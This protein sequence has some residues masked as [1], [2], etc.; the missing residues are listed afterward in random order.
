MD[1]QKEALQRIISTL[2]NKNDEI[3]NFVDTLNHTLKGVQTQLSQCNNALENSEELLEFATRSLDIKEPEEFSKAARQIKDRV[4]MASAFR[5]SLK[6]K[7][8]DNMTHLMVDFSQERQM[9][10]TLKFLPVPKAPEIDI[11]DCLVADNSVTVAW[12][13]PEEDN[14][15]DHYIL[16]YRKT[17]FDGLPR[18]KDERCWEIIDN[19]KGLEYTLSGLKFDSK[20]MNFRVR[21]CNKAVAGEYSDPVTLETKAL[22][23]NLD[24][25]SSHL[26]LKVEDACVE[27][28]PTG[29]KGQDS[30]VKGKE[31]KGSVHVTSLKKHTRSGTPSP[32]RT[33]VGSRPPAVRGS[34]DR[35]TG[36]SYTVLG[37][38]AIESGQHYWE[39][40]A[41]KDCK[42]YSVGVAYKT[43]GK[44]DQL[45]KTNTS[46]CIHVNNWLQNTFAAKHNNK[47]KALDVTVPEK[48]GVFCDFDGGQLSFYDA[49]SK[50]L[51]YSF[52]TKFTQPVLPGFMVWCG[53]LALSTGM[54]V[55]SAVRT[56]QKSENGMTGSAS[57]LNNVTQKQV[58]LPIQ[59][60][61]NN[62]VTYETQPSE[63]HRLM[64][65]ISKNVILALFTLASSAFLLFQL[66]YYKH[67][68][69]AKN[70][71][72]LSKS[73][74]SRIGF[75]STQWRAVKKFI[76]LTSSQNVPVFLIDPLILELISKNFEQVK[77]TSS[78]SKCKFFC[79]Q[80][81]FTTFALQYHQWKN[82]EGWFPVAESMGFQCLK[83][84]N[85]DPRL[86]G[87]DSLSGT[88]IPLH[89]ICKWAT[90]AIHLVVFHGRSG[91]YLWHGHLRLKGHID[92]KFVPFRKLQF[93]RYP[94]A[95]DRP[96]LQQVTIDGLEVLIPKDPTHFLEEIP[97][98]RFI[99]CRYKEARTFFQQYLD[100]N[101][102]EAVTF[103]KSAK[104]LLQLAAKILNKLGVKFWLSSGTCLGWY[105]QCSII[106]YSKD[107]DLGVFIQD[108]K[109][110][111]ILAFQEAGLPLKHKFGKVED[112]LELSF[113]GKDGVKL[114]IFFFYEETDYMWNGG[115]Q[116]KTG[117]KFKYLFPKFTLCWT[118]FVDM[119][120][121]VPCETTEYIE[122][123][124][125][126]SWRIPIKTWD[127]KSSPPNVRPNGIWPISEWDEVIQ[128]Y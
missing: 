121:H 72:G 50:Q 59:K 32:K 97:H 83:T 43:L 1:A 90:H 108:Y 74:G 69:S 18:V 57:S 10:Q 54:Q 33:S 9:L 95:F 82:E 15:I 63:Y 80:R 41:Q 119:K 53:G 56:L 51:L 21:A 58:C 91:S 48:I 46:W 70:G 104:E 123:N 47:V 52:K 45:G 28:D 65:K 94:G 92:R 64:S 20:Y 71:A 96:E 36:E 40:K 87:I 73:K 16:E 99:E 89:C 113:Q 27:W 62:W 7:V 39:V 66:Y 68:L 98:S 125:G 115:T 124:Y 26:N 6:P 86:D 79:V 4:T 77:N 60:D 24:N 30:K 76:M 120:V 17:N 122:A 112:S 110:D 101:T 37:D 106:P 19:I 126:K 12:R 11:V 109:Y 22:N 118:E 14:K 67:Y 127:W 23:F 103:Q 13:M 84:E 61:E 44:F 35:F 117:K 107:V 5:L 102:G 42:S 111:I 38:T 81:D 55:P 31:N 25:S 105:R 116:A 49:D 93:G 2:A 3:Q 8:S 75:D 78:A 29:G 100:D 88:E 114:D 85:K 128:L 34:R